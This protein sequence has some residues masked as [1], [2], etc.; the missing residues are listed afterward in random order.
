MNRALPFFFLV[1][2]AANCEV[3][4]AQSTVTAYIKNVRVD[5]NGRGYVIFTE[6]LS[7][8]VA[9]CVSSSYLKHLSFDSSTD[10]GK[11]MYSA[12]LTAAAAHHEVT[13][14]GAGTCV[15]YPDAVED[16]GKIYVDFSE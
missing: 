5:A 6:D 9:T 3:C 7:G 13:A 15:A 16:M 1:F 4:S 11:S 10:A 2:L 14:K 8:D 12:I